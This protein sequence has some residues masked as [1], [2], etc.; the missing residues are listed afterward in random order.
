MLLISEIK[1]LPNENESLLRKLILKKLHIKDSDLLSYSIYKKSTD[2]RKEL[3]FKYQ[4]LAEV[5]NENKYLKIKNVS[6]YK[7]EDISV[8]K[9][10]TDIRPI[11][12][13]YGP[14]GIFS[15]YRLVE[16]GFKPIVLEKG[17][18]IE[19]RA[20]DVDRF[21]NEGILNPESNIQFGEGGAGTFSDAKLTTRVKSPY[22]DYCLDI[23]VKFGAKE[24]IKYTPHAHIG[25]DEVRKVIQRIT[26][27]LIE[28]GAEFHFEEEMEDLLLNE[29]HEVIG[30]KTKYREY[31]SKYVLFGV[32]HSAFNIIKRIYDLGVTMSAKDVAVGFR[33]EH[34]QSLI[35][36]NQ[37]SGGKLN[38]ASEYFLRYKDEKGVY[39][40][41]MCPGGIV[42]PA[43]SDLGRTLTNGM[44][45]AARDSGT[46]NSAIL[47]QVNKEE[48]GT[49]VLDGFEYLKNLEEKAYQVSNSYKALSCNIKDFV[50]GTDNDF[51]YQTTYPL[52]TVKYDFN[53][54]FNQKDTEILK[55]ALLFF[56]TKIKGFV[57][58]GIMVGPETRS[59]CPVRIDR[60]PETLES[61]NT[62]G[63]YP[64]GEGAGYGGG[65]TSC[66]ID[67]ARIADKIITL[68]SV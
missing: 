45:Y 15:T 47:I 63:L 21:F 58:K 1:L 36:E 35:D 42:V 66:A 14:S 2:A 52:G 8:K 55:K 5:K 9:V 62:K 56:D 32:G 38:E 46:A 27:Y 23:L 18:R 54:F 19:E 34:P 67:G 10:K 28:Q 57:D 68:F 60:N 64:M 20:K 59:S 50:Y 61:I 37:I 39:S 48:Y 22:N 6:L 26:D 16:A 53:K 3:V 11:V 43:A 65:I 24:S 49:G 25:T 17:K 33:V 7:K 13:G 4:V 31:M 30:V 40:F 12:V 29:N 44:S 51:V 41:C